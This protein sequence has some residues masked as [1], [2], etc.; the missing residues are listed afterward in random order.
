VPAEEL[1]HAV[2]LRTGLP[3]DDVVL[4]VRSASGERRWVS[5][6]AQPI[7]EDSETIA[8]VSSLFDITERKQA[9]EDLRASLEFRD[10]MMG[11]LGHDLRNPLGVITTSAS[12]LQRVKGLPESAQRSATRIVNNAERMARMIRDLLDYTRARGTG[13][14]MIPSPAD[15]ADLCKQVLDSM[16]AV[17]PDRTFILEKDGDTRGEWDVERL[18][19]VIANLVSNAVVHGREG[20]PVVVALDGTSEIVELAVHNEGE[21][22]PAKELPHVFEP[23]ARGNGKTNRHGEGLGLGLFI[24]R[25]I[26][27]AHDGAI[28]I[29]STGQ[30]GTTFTVRLPR[31]S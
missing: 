29:H 12:A 26:V 4:G 17:H 6:N 31:R 19:Q 13:L 18:L 11:V 5:V 1:P 9:E 30:E 25:E 24:V 7:T 15:L 14:P 23:F 20:A 27:R 22:I 21:P 28:H 10:R 2:A 16:E 3:V 8:V